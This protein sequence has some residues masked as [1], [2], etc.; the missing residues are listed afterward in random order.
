MITIQAL[1]A[2]CLT[3]IKAGGSSRPRFYSHQ[4]RPKDWIDAGDALALLKDGQF[5]DIP[6]SICDAA[7]AFR[8]DFVNEGKLAFPASCRLPSPVTVFRIQDLGIEDSLI[9]IGESVDAGGDYELVFAV[10]TFGSPRLSLMGRI[11]PATGQFG[12]TDPWERRS[13]D[14]AN[15]ILVVSCV[16]LTLLNEP[17]LVSTSNRGDRPARRFN[18]RG[19]GLALDCWHLCQWELDGKV[20]AKLSRDPSFHCVPL[21]YRRGHYRKAES[22]FVGAVELPASLIS[23]RPAGFYQYIE[24]QWVGHIAFG[25]KRHAYAPKLAFAG[26]S[27]ADQG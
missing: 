27:D 25:L 12:L 19:F 4:P 26:S 23:N 24:G 15:D 8:Q 2:L 9:V 7:I 10:W 6:P 14:A 17:R 22:H 5:F 13:P 11:N 1:A 21:H 18:Q 20:R 16:L 3:E